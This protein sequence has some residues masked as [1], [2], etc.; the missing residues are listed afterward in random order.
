MGYSCEKEGD[1]IINCPPFDNIQE[2]PYKAP[3]W[4][5][6]DKIIGFNHIPLKEINYTYGID[7]PQQAIYTYEEEL[8]GFY[9]I[10]ED[11]TNKR[12]ILPYE[13]NTPAW[14]P[15]GKWIAFS[16]DAQIFI[17]PFDG[18]DFDTSAMV[19]LTFE[20]RNFFPAWSPDGEWIAYDSNRDSPTGLYFIWKMKKNGDEK[21]RIAFAPNQGEARMPFWGNDFNIVYQQY[22][23]TS[24][25]IFTMDSS[26]NAK[27]RLT[28]NKD[29]DFL[30]KYSP[31]KKLIGFISQSQ[32]FGNVEL[33]TINLSSN[34]KLKLTPEG[35]QGFSW[36][37]DGKLVYI[38]YD[39]SRLDEKK[40]TL[41]IMNP[42]GSEKQQLTHNDFR[43]IN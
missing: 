18:V 38:N 40:G 33:W 28:S 3:I 31:N 4:H 27:T 32:E 21:T 34:E 30:P 8:A 1:D 41:W 16:R 26:G 37:P 24:A 15:D 7:C 43:I 12:R 25:E 22:T 23:D 29:R 19:Q 42:D 10:D 35:C 6:T 5:P 13:L 39:Y 17:M 11:G 36:S 14:S 2:S 9:L 20:G